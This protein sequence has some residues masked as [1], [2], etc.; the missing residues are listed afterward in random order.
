MATAK[1]PSHAIAVSIGDTPAFPHGSVRKGEGCKAKRAQGRVRCST[2]CSCCKKRG[3][4]SVESDS[5]CQTQDENPQRSSRRSHTPQNLSCRFLQLLWD[6][7]SHRGRICSWSTH[8]TGLGQQPWGDSP[9]MVLLCH[10]GLCTSPG[11]LRPRFK[12]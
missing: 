2:A 5:N 11:A 4:A 12:P 1:L 9:D 10:T 6:L 8:S 3:K 7:R